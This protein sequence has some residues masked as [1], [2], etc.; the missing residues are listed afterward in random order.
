M[1]ELSDTDI[2]R[3]KALFRAQRRGFRE[4]DLIFGAFADA[5]LMALEGVELERFEALLSV[6][7]WQMFDWVMGNVAV[8]RSHDHEV[9]ARL[10][11]YRNN[12][13]S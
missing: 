2:R 10:C 6:P 4:L 1:T 13:S 7:D 9:F 12:F 8:P 5:H 3:K 11:A